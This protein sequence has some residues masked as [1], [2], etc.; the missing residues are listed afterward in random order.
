MMQMQLQSGAFA[1][2]QQC[3]FTPDYWR[4]YTVIGTHGRM[5]NFGN[6]EDGTRIEVWNK[7]KWGNNAPDEVHMV[8]RP[9]GGHGG[10]DPRIVDEFL[11]FVRLGGPTNT[12]PL[13]ARFSVAAGCAATDSLRDH[14]NLR[15]VPDVPVEWWRYFNETY[16]DTHEVPRT[17]YTRP[18]EIAHT[19]G[20]AGVSG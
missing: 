8:E 12:S 11:R 13:A 3:H 1:S 10:A 2:Y 20:F 6:G 19:N 4:N 7:R 16:Q 9:E 5:E 15:R 18:T 17:V 14:G